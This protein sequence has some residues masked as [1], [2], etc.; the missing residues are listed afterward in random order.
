MTDSTNLIDRI[1]PNM[2]AS[3]EAHDIGDDALWEC[4]MFVMPGPDGQAAMNGYLTISISTPILGEPEPTATAIL[5][6][7]VLLDAQECDRLVADLLHRA[8]EMRSQ[9][10]AAARSAFEGDKT[11]DFSQLKK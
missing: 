11:F 5:N 10:I 3:I 2:E 9:Q 7:R 4:G 8:R 1:S 6:P